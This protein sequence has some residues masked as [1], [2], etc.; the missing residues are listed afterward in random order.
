MVAGL[1]GAVE[2]RGSVT[3][4]ASG[5]SAGR[6]R[7]RRMTDGWGS[8]ATGGA[9]ASLTA[10]FS[11]SSALSQLS[12]LQSCRSLQA[13]YVDHVWLVR[14]GGRRASAGII[15]SPSGPPPTLPLQ[16]ARTS[17]GRVSVVDGDISAGLCLLTRFDVIRDRR[18]C[19]HGRTW[20]R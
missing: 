5:T 15:L 10:S 19:Q 2:G 14:R 17:S 4:L 13:I 18:A 3:G 1:A 16:P 12:L 6:V 7:M 8:H 20:S 9:L 11:L